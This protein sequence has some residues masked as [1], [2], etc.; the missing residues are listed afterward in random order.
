MHRRAWVEETAQQGGG[1]GERRVGHHVERAL[2]Q[3]QLGRVALDHLHLPVGEAS[4][5]VIGP[6]R[7]EL[8][9]EHAR[10][11]LHEVTGDRAGAGADVE[12]EVAG[13]DVRTRDETSRPVVS[14]AVPTPPRRPRFRG[15]D[16]P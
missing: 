7:V 1:D 12:D 13:L 14:E 6:A 4:A 2:W 5:E 15:H 11:S 3:P 16:A 8:H 9:G 10:T